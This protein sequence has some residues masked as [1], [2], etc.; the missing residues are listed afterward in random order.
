MNETEDR[1]DQSIRALNLGMIIG[2]YDDDDE[3]TFFKIDRTGGPISRGTQSLL[4]CNPSAFPKWEVRYGLL[5]TLCGSDC[6]MA[7]VSQSELN[8]CIWEARV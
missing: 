6:R 2:F 7:L 3:A 8:Q 4:C 5:Y 1:F